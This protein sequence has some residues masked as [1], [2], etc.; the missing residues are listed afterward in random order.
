M[1]KKLY[2]I[3]SEREVIKPSLYKKEGRNIYVAFDKCFNVDNIPNLNTFIIS[4]PAYRQN[5]DSICR[6][7]NLFFKEYDKDKEF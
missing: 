6:Y 5:L 4:R 3:D 7:S 1:A 2:D